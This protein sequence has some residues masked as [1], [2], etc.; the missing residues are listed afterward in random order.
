[1]LDWI[2]D[3]KEWVFSGVGVVVLTIT[4]NFMTSR[5]ERKG[6]VNES[7]AVSRVK[8][9]GDVTINQ[10]I[11]N[12]SEVSIQ[13]HKTLMALRKMPGKLQECRRITAR[14]SSSSWL[15]TAST[16]SA[17]SVIFY[18]IMFVSKST[19]YSNYCSI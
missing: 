5:K 18:V 1:M 15:W 16:C 9:G 10:T 12:D 11:G 7:Q 13:A 3:N 6:D 19:A 8:A 17:G 4:Y 14:S 2:V